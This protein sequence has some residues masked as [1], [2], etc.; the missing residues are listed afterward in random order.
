LQVINS[1]PGILVAMF[2]AVLEKAL[3]L[4]GAEFGV[5]TTFD[6][7]QIHPVAH[8]GVSP[9]Y[10]EFLAPSLEGA[11]TRKIAVTGYHRQPNRRLFRAAT[12]G[13]SREFVVLLNG[14]T[15]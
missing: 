5:L 11:A 2:D 9:E 3:G 13:T 8:R 10:A 12:R 14:V 15:Q 4:C 1:S 6:G 7:R